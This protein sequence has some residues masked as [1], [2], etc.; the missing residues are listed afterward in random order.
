M[1]QLIFDLNIYQCIVRKCQHL[2]ISYNFKIYFHYLSDFY[3]IFPFANARQYVPF[4]DHLLPRPRFF[5]L[6]CVVI[7]LCFHFFNLLTAKLYHLTTLLCYSNGFLSL[8]TLIDNLQNNNNSNQHL[9]NHT[10]Y[11]S[12]HYF[13]HSFFQKINVTFLIGCSLTT[14]FLLSLQNA[15]CPLLFCILS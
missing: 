1:F 9:K 8:L 11:S 7:V 4:G 15:Q 10:F 12:V 13:C 3:F 5:F 2:Y 14:F 6:F